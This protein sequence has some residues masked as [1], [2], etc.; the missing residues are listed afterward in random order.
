MFLHHRA[1]AAAMLLVAATLSSCGGESSPTAPI[2][3]NPPL[4]ALS[5]LST[6]P[7]PG[8]S[9]VPVTSGFSVK[10]SAPI[11]PATV[12][13]A[14][15][16]H[17][18][19]NLVPGTVSA[20]DSIVTFTP[21]VTLRASRSY[22]ATVTTA[23]RDVEGHALTAA[24]S[25]SA[26]TQA[27]QPLGG[28]LNASQ[29]LDLAGSPYALT[30]DLQIAYGA[31]LTIAPGVVVEGAGRKIVVYGALSA[32]GTANQL[33][34]LYDVKVAPGPNTDTQPFVITIQHAL[35]NGGRIYDSPGNAA[36]GSLVLRD[37]RLLGLE[38]Y[39]YVWY[40]VA[41]C[42][43]ERNV[44]VSCG[45]LTVGTSGAVKVYVRN[46]VFHGQTT[47]YAIENWAAYNTSETIVALNSFL[48]TD[49]VA[50]RLPTGYTSN[51][52]AATGNYW[53]TTSASTIAGMIFDQND[54]LASS[55]VIPFQPILT[56]PDAATPDPAPWI[57][58]VPQGRPRY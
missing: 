34:T 4:I 23:I 26:T 58:L 2:V 16:L 18:G 54:D 12:A 13:G 22:T 57:A 6:G 8:A 31:T 24:H 45:G 55:G 39:L 29:T 49:R 14:F 53:G 30:S 50:V 48:S 52:L 27:G 42:Y 1:R 17:D 38:S 25:W 46:N 56:S 35:V 47:E 19:S 43:I 40:P 3:I 36:Y 37:S 15:T 41:D 28:I 11:N 51:S 33:V 32:V 5:V 10:F 20:A 21:M 9:G 44:F 7:A